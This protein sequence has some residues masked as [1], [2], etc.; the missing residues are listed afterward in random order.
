MGAL[1]Q[2]ASRPLVRRL[3][4]GLWIAAVAVFLV[5]YVARH[6]GELRQYPWT[7]APW[8][9]AAALALAMIRRFLGGVRWV[10]IAQQRTTPPPA[11]APPPGDPSASL[12]PPISTLTPSS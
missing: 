5:Y 4:Q 10:L 11:E 3:V 9:L 7:F 8:W 6:W 2:F 12:T 1:R